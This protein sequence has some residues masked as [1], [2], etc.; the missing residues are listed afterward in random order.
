MT[1]AGAACLGSIL[2]A[3]LVG[4]LPARSEP[5]WR[6]SPPVVIGEA[7]DKN[8]AAQ[9]APRKKEEARVADELARLPIDTIYVEGRAESE[10]RKAPWQTTEQRFASALNAGNPE[11]NGGKIRHGMFYDGGVYWAPEPLTF[12]YYNIVNRFKD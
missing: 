10:W 6:I 9:P 5:T 11:V 2:L 8:Q 12:I 4:A 3:S 7:P 1:F